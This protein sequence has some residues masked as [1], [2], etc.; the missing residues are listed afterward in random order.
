MSS[1]DTMKPLESDWDRLAR[2]TDEEIDY[3]DIPPLNEE[4]FSRAKVF[5]PADKRANFVQLDPDV[6]VWFQSQN[7]EYQKLIN[8]ILRK[9]IEIQEEVA[10]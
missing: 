6:V 2:M 4:F 5:I 9:Y 3:S 10:K 1:E 8:L 7:R